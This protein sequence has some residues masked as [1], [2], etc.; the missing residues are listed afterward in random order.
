MFGGAGPSTVEA[1]WLEALNGNNALGVRVLKRKNRRS[2][3]LGGK[4]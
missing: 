4:I 3:K 1:F 2:D